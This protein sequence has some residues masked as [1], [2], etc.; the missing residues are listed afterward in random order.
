M[1]TG[2]ITDVGEVQAIETG[3]DTRF[4]IATRY[5][6]GSIEIGVSI[7]CSGACL[8]VVEKGGDDK[9]QWFSV[10]ASGETLSRTSLGDWKVGTSVNLERSLKVGDEIGGHIVTGHVDGVGSVASITPEGD[11]LRFRF[12]VPKDLLPFVA[13]KGSIT[14][15][16][17]SL[18][19]NEVEGDEFGVNIIPHTQSVTSFGKMKEGDKIN[20]EI[21]V[22]ARY[23]A[24]LQEMADQ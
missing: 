23:V 2:I 4:V 9:S 6:T 1:F 11:S 19:V 15:E 3:G 18:T 7:A 22:L 14:V 20:L 21:D 13:S 12:R 16:G 24:R 5:D 8:T 10:D 17:V